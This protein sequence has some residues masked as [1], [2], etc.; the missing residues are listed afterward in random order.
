LSFKFRGYY[1]LHDVQCVYS[2]RY[3]KVA[4]GINKPFGGG[5]D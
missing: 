1:N 4:G 2:L 3:I 5:Y